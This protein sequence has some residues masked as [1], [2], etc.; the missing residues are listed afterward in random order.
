MDSGEVLLR[1]YLDGEESAFDGIIA[2]YRRDVTAYAFSIVRDAYAAEDVAIEAF[3]ELVVHKDR[4]NFS[5]P[6]RSYLLMVCRSRAIDF[7]RKSRRTVRLGDR[8]EPY[9]ER[10]FEE[11]EKEQALDAVRG[12]V[13]AL[14]EK[15]RSAVYLVY[16]EGLSYAEAARVLR[17]SPKRVD[18]LVSRAK[19]ILRSKLIAG[20]TDE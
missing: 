7:L 10:G 5:I 9:F 19:G 2:L 17:T 14:P 12:E 13:K 1:R 3:A 4:Y 15:Y 20:E 8:D 18:Y 11:A 16:Y 6:L